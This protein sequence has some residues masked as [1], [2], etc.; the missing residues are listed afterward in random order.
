LFRWDEALL[1]KSDGGVLGNIKRWH[2]DIYDKIMNK[3]ITLHKAN[4]IINYRMASDTDTANRIPS[5][6]IASV[7]VSVNVSD[8]VSVS[9]NVIES[10]KQIVKRFTPP[11]IEELSEIITDRF[12]AE[13]YLDY[14]NSNGWIVGRSKMKDWKAA[15]RNWLR[16]KKKFNPEKPAPPK[17][18]FDEEFKKYGHIKMKDL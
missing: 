10:S 15:A 14:Y 7:A 16:N 1:K 11:T 13:K 2:P 17:R 5:D 8:S 12:E 3:E 4:E 9:D 18:D 6:T